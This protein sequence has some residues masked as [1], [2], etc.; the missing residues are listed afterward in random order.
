MSSDEIDGILTAIQK[1]HQQGVTLLVVEHNMRILDLCD[2]VVVISFGRK[3]AEG[4]PK[5][6]RENKEVI[7]A[8]FGDAY[9]A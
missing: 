4:S 3:I 7:E 8:Y 1:I 2:R 9:V 6:V 5:E